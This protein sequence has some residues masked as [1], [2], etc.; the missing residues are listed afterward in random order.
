[1]PALIHQKSYHSSQRFS[2]IN[3]SARRLLF[4]FLVPLIFF[5]WVEIPVA[6]WQSSSD[7][8]MDCQSKLEQYAQD[9]EFLH[10]LA[11]PVISNPTELAELVERYTPLYN[12]MQTVSRNEI[13]DRF[14][15]LNILL[16]LFMIFAGEEQGNPGNVRLTSVDL[17]SSQDSAIVRL[18]DVIGIPAPAGWVFIHFYDSRDEMPELI[19]KA[20]DDP[21]VDGVTFLSRYIAILR[22]T[23]QSW[24]ANALQAQSQPAIVSHELV[25]AYVHSAIALQGNNLTANLPK[26]FEEGLASYLS[27]SA[28]DRSIITPNLSMSEAAPADYQH[29]AKIFKYLENR[30]GKDKLA[31]NIR[32]SVQANDASLLYRE[33]GIPN[34]RWLDATVTEWERQQIQHRVVLG[35]LFLGI[36]I[37]ALYFSLPELECECGFT[38]RNRDFPFGNCPDCGR[39]VLGARRQP[40]HS[41]ME[42]FFPGCQVCDR[43]YLPWQRR[44]LHI[45]QR[46]ILVWVDTPLADGPP[47]ARYVHRICQACSE[48]SQDVAA[49]YQLLINQK[50]ERSRAE[51]RPTYKRWLANAPLLPIAVIN[52]L[53]LPFDRAVE[54]M[55]NSALATKYGDWI[56]PPSPFHFSDEPELANEDSDILIPP[57]NYHG[58][59]FSEQ[60][61]QFGSIFRT[62]EDIISILWEI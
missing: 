26:W 54:L 49:R 4:I 34:D 24:V 55:L 43:H 2:G 22:T 36:L 5:P 37:S 10:T 6:A 32:L 59:I 53:D 13:D 57:L 19:R 60:T 12:C 62:G 11:N 30:L 23:D 28:R 33:M 7:F 1:M 61:K 58:V 38:G 44:H 20:F 40:A 15:T 45:H 46:M 29:Y 9:R 3:F 27:R 8:Q 31:E 14:S 16:D 50:I 47:L 35:L 48:Q 41:P 39:P 18:R 56:A 42:Y 21:N 17:Q 52:Q 25:H 51:N